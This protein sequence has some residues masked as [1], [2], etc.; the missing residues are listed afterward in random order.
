M[1][2]RRMSRKTGKSLLCSM[3]KYDSQVQSPRCSEL[4]LIQCLYLG[5]GSIHTPGVYSAAIPLEREFNLHYLV[6]LAGI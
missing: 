4:D 5:R 6:F 3:L 1:R 2:G